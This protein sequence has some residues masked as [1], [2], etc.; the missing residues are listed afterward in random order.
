MAFRYKS[1]FLGLCPLLNLYSDSHARAHLRMEACH[2]LLRYAWQ[3]TSHGFDADG[4]P[5]KRMEEGFFESM[6]P[7][8]KY[9]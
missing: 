8:K 7:E 5:P 6:E 3:S 2:T 9:W 1:E 4:S